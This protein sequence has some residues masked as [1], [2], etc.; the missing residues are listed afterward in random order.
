MAT[1]STCPACDSHTSAVYAA[2][3]TGKNCPHCGLNAEAA[4]AVLKARQ[5]HVSEELVEKYIECQKANDELTR[6]LERAQAVLTSIS[7]AVTWHTTNGEE[8]YLV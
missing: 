4:D 1:K 2:F 3:M 6:A 5:A 8:G 7:A